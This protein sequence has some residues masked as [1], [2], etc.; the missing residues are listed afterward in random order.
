MN[1]T[2]DQIIENM[3]FYSKHLFGVMVGAS[4]L[5]A[6]SLVIVSMMLYYSSGASQ[7]DLSSPSYTDVRDQIEKDDN[8]SDYSNT[9][10]VNQSSIT[11]FEGLYNE[12]VG[13]IESVDIFGGDPLSPESL[14]ISDSS[15]N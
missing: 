8:F 11:E 14:G 5:I 6:F 10:A 2:N 9:G 3:P 15:T 7:L 12:K 1:E 4:I 13:K